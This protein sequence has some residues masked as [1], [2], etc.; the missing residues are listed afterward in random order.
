MSQRSRLVP[1]LTNIMR[2]A[3]EPERS[4]YPEESNQDQNIINDGLS[5]NRFQSNILYSLFCLGT[6]IFFGMDLG[7]QIVRNGS[8]TNTTLLF[9]GLFLLNIILWVDFNF[10]L[11]Q[12]NQSNRGRGIFDELM[13][14][15]SDLLVCVLI[16]PLYWVSAKVRWAS[17]L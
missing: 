2:F 12:Q 14:S 16:A 13:D 7:Y 1:N 17:V 4:E 8:F 9:F 15:S 10:K 11:H 3:N 6:T 5:F